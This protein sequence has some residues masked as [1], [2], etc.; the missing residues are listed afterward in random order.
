M[1]TAADNRMLWL[2]RSE[3]DTRRKLECMIARGMP[4]PDAVRVLEE[5]GRTVTDADALRSPEFRRL[6][7]EHTANFAHEMAVD[8]AIDNALR[9]TP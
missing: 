9:G 4:E 7:Q 8:A 5:T 3:T 1:L 2:A 6:L